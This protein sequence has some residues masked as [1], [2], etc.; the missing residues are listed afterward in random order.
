MLFGAEDL[1][2]RVSKQVPPSVRLTALAPSS[3]GGLLAKTPS[4][5]PQIA[6]GFSG[7]SHMEADR[8]YSPWKDLVTTGKPSALNTHQGD[9]IK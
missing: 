9:Q 4:R 2:L 1:C 5:C 3:L 7:S 6:L 8:C